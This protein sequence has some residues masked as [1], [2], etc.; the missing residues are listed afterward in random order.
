MSG[1]YAANGQNRVPGVDIWPHL[2]QGRDQAPTS[3]PGAPNGV[4]P[5]PL[6]H[7]PIQNALPGDY[8]PPPP[9]A[10]PA[11]VH[12]MA[13]AEALD[14]DDFGGDDGAP[15]GTDVAQ[16]DLGKKKRRPAKQGDPVTPQHD[17][18]EAEVMGEPSI[19]PAAG[20]RRKP[21]REECVPAMKTQ[22]TVSD[23]TVAVNVALAGVGK[24]LAGF[25]FAQHQP[26]MPPAPP[27]AEAFQDGDPGPGKAPPPS[28][29]N[30]VLQP[31]AGPS[32]DTACGE[33]NGGA[34]YN[35]QGHVPHVDVLNQDAAS[36]VTSGHVGRGQGKPLP[37]PAG[38]SGIGRP[39]PH[40]ARSSA[41]KAAGPPPP[42]NAPG[43]WAALRAP[44]E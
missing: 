29:P 37:T 1:T 16:P 25:P 20:R 44:G 40:E 6:G 31:T 3:S 7:Q 19:K 42:V 35:N 14:P 36:R 17:A 15:E 8:T 9:F 11:P 22:P 38:S 41:L 30:Q 34:F 4:P 39:A 21:V 43:A 10:G 32:L 23:L 13:P 33:H 2:G 26:L 5:S 28:H 12:G 18:A 24:A 27:A